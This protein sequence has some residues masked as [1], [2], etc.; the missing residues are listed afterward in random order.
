MCVLLER[1]LCLE[2]PNSR[3][4]RIIRERCRDNEGKID[5]KSACVEGER[6]ICIDRVCAE[7]ENDIRREGKG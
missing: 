1:V 2:L 3:E 7:R 5:S 4:R 6:T